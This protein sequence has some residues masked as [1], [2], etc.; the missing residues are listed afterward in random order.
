MGVNR[1]PP[2]H[3]PI[4]AVAQMTGISLDTLRA[5]ERRY[6]A[7]TPRRSDRGRLYTEADVNRLRHLGLLVGRG[8]AIGTIA[9]LDDAQLTRLVES[10]EALSPGRSVAAPPARLDDITA[11]LDGYDFGAIEQSLNRFA[12]V[13][14]PRDL[15]FAVILP[16]LNDVGDR[17]QRGTLRPAQEHL[18]SAIVRSVL[19]GLLRVL[20]RTDALPRVV[21]A[22]PSGERHELGLLCAAVLAAAEGFGVVYLG[23]DLPATDIWHA[24][25]RAEARIAIVS[26][27]T[28]GAVTRTELRALARRPAGVALW[29]GGPAASDALSLL[30]GDTR[31]V[32]TLP[33]V[34]T[35]LE[36]YAR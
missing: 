19:G 24:A 14:A 1:T 12:A 7:V 33:D 9:G 6:E 31:H 8:H 16:L 35:L 21:C 5:W 15:I 20:T 26:L 32:A 29:V 22:A 2:V 4:R 10:S 11:A 34:V 13:L 27:T 30:G 3:Y 18:V 36:L 17:W 23:P 25:S 28:P